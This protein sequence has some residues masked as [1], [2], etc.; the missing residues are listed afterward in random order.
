MSKIATLILAAGASSRMGEPKQ[1]LPVGSTTLLGH[2]IEMALQTKTDKVYC[3]LGAYADLIHKEITQYPIEIIANKDYKKG[4]SSSIIA[5]ISMLL[6]YDAVVILLAD[7]PKIDV[8]YV[9]KLITS[10]YMYPNK[11]IASS[12]GSSV[13][14]P[15]IFPRLFYKNLL[16]L[17]GDK[18][19][20]NF[21]KA[22]DHV[23]AI[24]HNALI[25]IDTKEA[26]T[27]FLNRK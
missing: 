18:G 12:Y 7:Q 20:R 5:G 3:V 21:L 25:D 8:G 27:H 23:H 24:E 14:V 6:H 16:Q 9:N 4:L 1:L 19:A 15:A 13:G 26:Y 17:E 22:N 2:I 11:M 10:S